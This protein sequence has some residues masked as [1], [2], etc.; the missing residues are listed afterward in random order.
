MA[1]NKHN[2]YAQSAYYCNGKQKTIR[3]HHVILGFPKNSYQI[4]HIN[5]NGL[6]NRIENLR[7]CTNQQNQMNQKKRNGTTSKYKGVYFN[8]PKNKWSAYINLNG[9]NIYLGSYIKETSAAI[10]YNEAAIRHF[11]NFSQL[12]IIEDEKG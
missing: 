6:D 8:V 5:G 4:D 2:K 1:I 9:E 7:F 10:A 12:N 11:K 3:L